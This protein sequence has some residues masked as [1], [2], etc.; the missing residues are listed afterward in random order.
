MST[1]SREFVERKSEYAIDLLKP[2]DSPMYAYYSSN[3]FHDRLQ[4]DEE[5]FVV[6]PVMLDQLGAVGG[7]LNLTDLLEGMGR[8]IANSGVTDIG[9]DDNESLNDLVRAHIRHSHRHCTCSLWHDR[10]RPWAS[11]AQIESYIYC[12]VAASLLHCLMRKTDDC[13]DGTFVDRVG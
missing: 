11:Q 3:C 4:E 8:M 13:F 9:S 12:L 10:C 6:N 5:S 1:H 2:N 7:E